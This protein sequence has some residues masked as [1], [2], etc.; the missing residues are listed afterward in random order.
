MENK[1][2]R[3]SI[4]STINSIYIWLFDLGEFF[5]IFTF[6]KM[7]AYEKSKTWMWGTR[8]TGILLMVISYVI[9]LL[10]Y[11]QK[12]MKVE[13]EMPMPSEREALEHFFNNKVNMHQDGKNLTNIWAHVIMTIMILVPFDMLYRAGVPANNIALYL[14]VEVA[15]IGLWVAGIYLWG[16]IYLDSLKSK[17]GAGDY[18][19]GNV[20][21]VDKYIKTTHVR[22]GFINYY[23]VRVKGNN[24]VCND[25]FVSEETYAEISKD[26][27][28]YMVIMNHGN[29]FLNR[30]DLFYQK[31][32]KEQGE[33]K[34]FEEL[35]FN[36]MF[37]GFVE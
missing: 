23:I 6:L 9:V 25:F 22:S 35:H 7:F 17:I 32:K 12:K 24:L 4:I 10:F 37:N 34:V 11:K 27:K 16:K 29:C 28:L 18:V 20:T 13:L 30:Y 2:Y 8:I 14:V 21:Y 5:I 36:D 1:M 33:V 19:L 15:F 31:D 3:N 26:T